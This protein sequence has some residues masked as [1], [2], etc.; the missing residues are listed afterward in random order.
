MNNSLQHD[1]NSFVLY[2]HP[3]KSGTL[4]STNGDLVHGCFHD[5]IR[6]FAPDFVDKWHDQ[7]PFR[8]FTLS[9]LIHYQDRRGRQSP[10]GGILLREDQE[11]LIRVTTLTR[12]AWEVVQGGLSRLSVLN[13]GSVPFQLAGKSMSRHNLAGSANYTDLCREFDQSGKNPADQIRITFLSPTAFKKGDINELFPTPEN[14]FHSLHRKWK[15]FCNEWVSEAEPG[16]WAESWM[17]SRYSLMTRMLD[18]GSFQQVGFKGELYFRSTP[19]ADKEIKA[20]GRI[21]ARFAFYSGVG[22]ATTRGMGSVVTE[23]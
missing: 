21:L 13:I 15:Y 9:G 5:M 1:L 17:T 3:L 19:H 14:F 16:M 12:Q 22:Y 11:Y 2:L 18:F 20:L 10:S 6:S 7:S 23:L 8:P 4:P